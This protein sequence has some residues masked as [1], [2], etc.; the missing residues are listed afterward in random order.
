[1]GTIHCRC[2]HSFSDGELPCPHE[3]TLLSEIQL[4]L[5]LDDI[6]DLAARDC[7]FEVLSY[8]AISS[9]RLPT[10]QCP[11]CKRLLVF[12]RGLGEPATSYRPE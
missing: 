1:M 2:G 11:E 3:W 6:I 7:D 9:R 10:Y 12:E 4:G 5:A 8:H